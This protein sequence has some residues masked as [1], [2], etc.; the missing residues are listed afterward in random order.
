MNLSLEICQTQQGAQFDILEKMKEKKDQIGVIRFCFSIVKEMKRRTHKP[1]QKRPEQVKDYENGFLYDKGLHLAT[2]PGKRIKV[3]C[4]S[5]DVAVLE[6]EVIY[7]SRV[8]YIDIF[9]FNAL[10]LSG[11]H[12]N[13]YIY[14]DPS[15]LR[16][17][18]L[19]AFLATKECRIKYLDR[20]ITW[21]QQGRFDRLTGKQT[22]SKNDPV[23]TEVLLHFIN[24][25]VSPAV[26][27]ILCM[28][29]AFPGNF[30]EKFV[31]RR[32][33]SKEQ[34]DEMFS[35]KEKG[36][37][38]FFTKYPDNYHVAETGRD[39]ENRILYEVQKETIV[40]IDNSDEDE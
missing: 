6:E 1:R 33:V 12:G 22:N 21:I 11:T 35:L 4:P 5:T 15:S 24:V 30:G 32:R 9:G 23:G 34:R 2:K 26:A 29:R 37:V 8:Y 19:D 7:E 20:F 36:L 27:Y 38:E 31:Q 18:P 40:V 25:T 10:S 39:S 16:S 17:F 3:G 13:F 28:G 14:N